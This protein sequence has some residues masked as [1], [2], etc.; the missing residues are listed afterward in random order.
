MSNSWI[1]T[2][3]IS[4]TMNISSRTLY[5]ATPCEKCDSAKDSI[6]CAL[7]KLDLQELSHSKSFN[8]YKK[9][10]V[11]FFE[12]NHP[13]G[14]HCIYSGKVKIHKLGHDGKD[15]ILRLAKKGQVI[16]Y[17]ALLSDD[18]YHASATA[19]EDS[20]ICFFPKATYQNLIVTNPLVISQIMRL[21]S[22]DLKS[23]EQKAMDLAQ[24]NVHERIAETILMLKDF[25]G[26][27]A[28]GCTLNSKIT[29]E[30]IANIAGT[31]TETAIRTLSD[32]KKRK[33]IDLIGKKIKI[34]NLQEL[35]EI[36]N[37]TD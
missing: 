20:T 4:N 26:C 33:Y 37:L 31:T 6:F 1:F 5:E 10:Q 29:R 12:R 30:N 14:L 13:L 16:G 11:I 27:E 35:I 15:Q 34:I 9:G 25:F 17:R 24:K 36:A 7:S 22:S 28:D 23:A 2:Q 19:L 3:P 8:T 21:L 32:L 18:C